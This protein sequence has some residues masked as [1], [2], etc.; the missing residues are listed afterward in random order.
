MRRNRRPIHAYVTARP[1]RYRVYFISRENMKAHAGNA[2]FDFEAARDA[3]T[4]GTDERNFC[5][6]VRLC[7]KKVIWVDKTA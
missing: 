5:V 4:Y 1:P 7:D 3:A 6:I 2:F